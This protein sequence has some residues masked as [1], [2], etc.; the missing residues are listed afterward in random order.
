MTTLEKDLQVNGTQEA[1]RFQVG[2]PMR[3]RIFGEKVWREGWVETM[4]VTEIL[5]RSSREVAAS[6]GMEIRIALPSPQSGAHGGIIVG[7]AR[8]LRC[9]AMPEM[10]AQNLIVASISSPRLLHVAEGSS[11]R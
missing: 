9:F 6:Q 10:Q 4:S 5:F 11:K 2:L 3:F 8:V 1:I 7:K